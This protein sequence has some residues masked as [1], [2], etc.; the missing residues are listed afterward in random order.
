MLIH[1]VVA[2]FTTLL[3]VVPALAQTATS[4]TTTTGGTSGGATT[5]SGTT[6]TSTGGSSTKS[7]AFASLSPG[8]Q[9]IARALYEA[10]TTPSN[11]TATTTSSKLTLDQIAQMKQE[12]QGWGNVFREM[13]AQGRVDARNL[14]AVVSASKHQGATPVAANATSGGV[15]S[16]TTSGGT[17]PSTAT[18]SAAKGKSDK[19]STSGANGSAKTS[20]PGTSS[21]KAAY[22]STGSEYS[23]GP[24][25]AVASAGAGK[26]PSRTTVT[27]GS[28]TNRAGVATTTV[29]TGAGTGKA[30]GAN[31]HAKSGK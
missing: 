15:T 27:S 13:K 1:T 18:T 29:S 23:T 25:G 20:A 12:G 16:G 6:T 21:G 14:G 11:G 2:L 30:G 28:S 19:T 22:Q 7:G 10:Q 8:N 17:T 4:A 24:V 31:S 9:K 26:V 3:M 5:T